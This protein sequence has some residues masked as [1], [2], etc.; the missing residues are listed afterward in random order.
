[1]ALA[2]PGFPREALS[3][4]RQLERNNSREWFQPRKELF[5]RRVREPMLRLVE[6]LCDDVRKFAADHVVEPKKALY[7][8]YRDTRFSKDKTPYKTHIAA[9]FHR[10]NLDRH[11]SAG[12]YFHVEP[13]KV[14]IASGAYM[15]GPVELYAIRTWLTEHY[16][17]FLKL[18]K[19]A[20]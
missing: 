13:T 4:L 7:G 19:P 3:F 18:I 5:E 12:Y 16:D 2:F 10:H 17:D 11:S 8:I 6:L 1:M 14:G 20:E 15:P 9:I